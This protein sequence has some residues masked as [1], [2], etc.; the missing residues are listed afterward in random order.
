MP[1][2]LTLD[3][4][5]PIKDYY[6]I[7]DVTP[8]SSEAEI[9]K[10]FRKLA[11]RF[12]PDRNIGNPYAS[13][14][15]REI[16]EAYEVLSDPIRRNQYHQKRWQ[17][18]SDSF[19][20]TAGTRITPAL[21]LA[22]AR[23]IEHH[24]SRVD[25]FRMNHDALQQ[26]LEQLLNQDH[27]RILHEASDTGVNRNIVHSLLAIIGPLHFRNLEPLVPLL[28]AVAGTDNA[29]LLTI[30]KAVRNKRMEYY[31]EKYN[32]LLVVLLAL[33]ISLLIYLLA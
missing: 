5:M 29:L 7:L 14:H 12:H 32:W 2:A 11:M 20:K 16:Q 9:K 27:L 21:I 13:H 31:R 10:A 4:I 30:H 23:K 22:E 19:L 26:Q 17:K 25:I 8:S 3:C 1:P 33:G 15:F 24:I 18:S 6:E 28:V